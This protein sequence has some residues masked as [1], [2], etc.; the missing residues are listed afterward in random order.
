MVLLI[1]DV[2]TVSTKIFEIWGF[3]QVQHRPN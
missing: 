2:K 3:N 1:E